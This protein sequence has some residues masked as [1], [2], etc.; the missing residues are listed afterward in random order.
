MWWTNSVVLAVCDVILTF[1]AGD[2]L[3]LFYL[4]SCDLGADLWILADC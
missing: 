1:S 3:S 2:G 4:H